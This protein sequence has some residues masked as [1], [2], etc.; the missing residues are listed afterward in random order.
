MIVHKIPNACDTNLNKQTEKQKELVEEVQVMSFWD[1]KHKTYDY[2][3][4]G[5]EGTSEG[6]L[7]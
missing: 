5:L 7:V 4:L 3:K 2:R 1:H 6:H